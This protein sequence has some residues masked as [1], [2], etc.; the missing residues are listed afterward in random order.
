M[1]VKLVAVNPS[2]DDQAVVTMARADGLPWCVNCGHHLF[3][4]F[5][6]GHH[7]K[8]RRCGHP[9]IVPGTTA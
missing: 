2:K 1:T 7:Y 9:V 4:T 6:K 8:C 5:I 3:K